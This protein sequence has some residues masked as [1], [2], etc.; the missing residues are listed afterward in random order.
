ML[1]AQLGKD[2]QGAVP[3]IARR[4][5]VDGGGFQHLA[6]GVDHGNLAAG[7]QA[8]VQRQGGARAGWCSEQQV[9]QVAGEDVDRLV[10]GLLAQFAEQVGFQV[11]VELDLPGPAHH[12]A[13]PLVGGATPVVDAET[14][15]DHHFARVHGA[16]GLVSDLQGAAEDAF[17]APTEDR[18]GAVRRHV[19]QRFVVLEVV[20]EL[21]AFGF[22]ASDHAGA[23][24]SVVLEEA[25]QALEQ[26]GIFGEALHEDVLGAFEHGLDVGEAFLGID[27]ARGFAFRVQAWVV[28]QAVSQLAE[29]GFQGDLALGAA[30]LLVRQ[31][32][33]FEAR[34]GVGEVDL[35]GQLRGQ[36]ALFLDAGEDAGAALVEFAQVAQAF[37]QVTQLGVV[38]AAGDF[39]AVARDKRHGGAFVEQGHGSGHLLR[40]DTELFGDTLVDAVHTPT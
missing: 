8:R 17:V 20:A 14:L 22:F 2:R 9:V 25:A 3:V 19:L 35:A 1:G 4:V 23:E 39:L 36:L 27:E 33:V 15:A 37:F 40:E 10:L 26:G 31:I 30:L 13:Q 21:G 32:Q 12:F 11:G 38:Q 18:Q 34:L 5:R 28:E 6:G 29:A 16:G 7:T 24:G